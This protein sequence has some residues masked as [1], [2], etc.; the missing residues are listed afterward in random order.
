MFQFGKSITLTYFIN[1]INTTLL[2]MIT[3]ANFHTQPKVL[4]DFYNDYN[5]ILDYFFEALKLSSG[6]FGEQKREA[7]HVTIKNTDLWIEAYLGLFPELISFRKYVHSTMKDLNIEP[8]EKYCYHP[9]HNNYKLSVRTY[10]ELTEY[11]KQL[12]TSAS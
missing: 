2:T 3:V 12:N 4:R 10:D 8:W 11:K 9:K 6:N 1:S 5:S 7:S